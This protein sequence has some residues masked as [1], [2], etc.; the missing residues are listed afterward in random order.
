MKISLGSVETIIRD[1]LKISARWVPVS[2]NLT[3]QDW[4]CRVTSSQEFLDLFTSDQDKFSRH[5]VTGDETWIHY[6]DLECK[7]ESMQWRHALP[8]PPRK[9][10]TQPSAG[11]I[12]ATIFWDN[13]GVL[14]IDYLPDKTTMNGQYY[15][16]LLLKLHQAIKD[17]RRGMLTRGVW[18]V[19][20]NSPVHKSTLP[21]KLFATVHSY[22]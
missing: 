5:I 7:Y 21:S 16:N 4:V 22:S 11:K 9:F 8:P 10:T 2:R 19:H 20:D 6:W 13:K 1:H 14:L 15:A 3:A 18:L 12:M 17:N